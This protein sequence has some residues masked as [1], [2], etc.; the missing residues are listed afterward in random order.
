MSS[1][2]LSLPPVLIV[3]LVSAG[4][5]FLATMIGIAVYFAQ[6]CR[7]HRQSAANARQHLRDEIR[8]G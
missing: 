8:R 5:V 4:V 2:L 1:P 6:I 3:D 7:N